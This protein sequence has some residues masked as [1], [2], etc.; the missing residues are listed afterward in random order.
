MYRRQGGKSVL[1]GVLSG[2]YAGGRRE[3]EVAKLPR[4]TK[5]RL[6]DALRGRSEPTPLLYHRA[7]ATR[8][9]ATWAVLVALLAFVVLTAIGFGN[10]SH[11]WAIAPSIALV[12]WSI[13]GALLGVALL[14]VARRRAR[15]TGERLPEGRWLLPLDIV[16]VHGGV[17][18]VLTVTP[19]GDA[20]DV[21]VEPAGDLVH[22]VL[23]F[24][25]GEVARFPLRSASEGEVAV[26]RLEHS[27]RLLEDLTYKADIDRAL[28]TD[29]FFDLRVD[30]SWRHVAPARVRATRV[31]PSS[32]PLAAAVVAGLALGASGHFLRNRLSDRAMYQRALREGTAEALDR[33]LAKGKRH[34][35]EA[36][37]AQVRILE[38]QAEAVRRRE[39]ERE[40]EERAERAGF[41]VEPKSMREMST[42]CVAKLRERS[43]PRPTDFARLMVDLVERDPLHGISMPF[44]IRRPYVLEK[45]EVPSL[46]REFTAREDVLV[47]AFARVFSEVCPA[48]VVRWSPVDLR[49]D[50]PEI[51]RQRL[52]IAYSVT[53]PGKTWTLPRAG[54]DT[55]TVHAF[56]VV[57]DVAFVANTGA[58][59]RF[60]LTM[61]PPEAPTMA[62]RPRSLFVLEGAAPEKGTFDERVYAVMT[63]R[64]F[65]QLYDE[66]YTHFFAGDPRVPLR[67]SESAPRDALP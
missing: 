19:L 18:Q 23:T 47:S 20:R 38:Q 26:L 50:P 14:A 51:G 37:A 24:E 2:A 35:E 21:S 17:P 45:R 9:R 58:P 16:E 15:V 62:M 11:P 29:V 52:E 33:Y 8:A 31:R 25:G 53:W 32:T 48:V 59:A 55:M 65:D 34:V 61:P 36:R 60:R 46:G 57:F 28:A 66:L 42:A 7:D 3:V 5:K 56:E 40:R 1:Q 44:A 54:G 63:A 64:A 4:A 12:P 27:Q 22:L 6:A 39:R 13:A 67:V 10:P 43:G 49:V 41:D 30:D